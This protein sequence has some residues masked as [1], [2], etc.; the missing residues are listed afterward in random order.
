MEY[1]IEAIREE[2]KEYYGT[3][4]YVYRGNA[5]KEHPFGIVELVCIDDL[6][7]DEIVDVAQENGLL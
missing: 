7:D 3:A 6:N 5:T 4:V 1:N 2:L